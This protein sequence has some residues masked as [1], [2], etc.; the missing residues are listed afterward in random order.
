MEYII[1]L[2]FVFIGVVGVMWRN[3]RAAKE[4]NRNLTQANVILYDEFEAELALLREEPEKDSRTIY[5]KTLADF[6]NP[7]LIEDLYVSCPSA[8]CGLEYLRIDQPRHICRECG[9]RFYE[10]PTA[11]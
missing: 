7:A 3:L 4:T 10:F 1:L 8:E 5:E 11:A 9:M 2:S 6:H